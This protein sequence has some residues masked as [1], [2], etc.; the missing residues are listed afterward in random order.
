M[1][2]L[3]SELTPDAPADVVPS[4]GTQSLKDALAGPERQIIREALKRHNWN[5]NET[6]DALG[7]NRTTLYKK[8]K[9]LGL[10]EPVGA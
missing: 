6:A 5:R 8:M 7:I 2:D 10:E 4:G 1:N 9:R 3:P